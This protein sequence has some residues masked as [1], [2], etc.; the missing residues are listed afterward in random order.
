M[1]IR[2]EQVY[3]IQGPSGEQLP[4]K[5]LMCNSVLQGIMEEGTSIIFTDMAGQAL[6]QPAAIDFFGSAIPNNHLNIFEDE[7]DP[8]DFDGDFIASRFLV[9]DHN[10][11]GPSKSAFKNLHFSV[12]DLEDDDED[13]DEEEDNNT[14]SDVIE[15]SGDEIDGRKI[16]REANGHSRRMRSFLGQGAEPDEEKEQPV[17]KTSIDFSPWVQ[18]SHYPSHKLSPQPAPE[19]DP[20][21]RIFVDVTQLG[22]L[23]V[24]SGDWVSAYSARDHDRQRV[25]Q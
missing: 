12:E 16:R 2:Y 19:D 14:F 21:A 7:A 6:D 8:F 18:K 9:K 23:R 4:V 11:M 15:D 3:N 24:F 22:K 5:V 13:E 17:K 1:I 10:H 25:T 20:E